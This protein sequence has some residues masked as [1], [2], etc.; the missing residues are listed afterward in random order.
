[1]VSMANPQGT[2]HLRVNLAKFGQ[3]LESNRKKTVKYEEPS[4]N[5]GELK[6]QPLKHTKPL[7]DKRERY[8][9]RETE[10]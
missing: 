8:V 10:R 1:M 4:H 5:R 2:A 3:A 7:T 9:R 6:K